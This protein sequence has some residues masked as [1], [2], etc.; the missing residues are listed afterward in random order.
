MLTGRM[1]AS[2][3]K[4]RTM[5]ASAGRIARTGTLLAAALLW[6]APA[7]AQVVHSAQFGFRVFFPRGLEARDANDVLLANLAPTGAIDGLDDSLEFD[8][9]KT[10]RRPCLRPFRA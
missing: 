2:A 9:C 3:S 8:F 5:T 10:D 4:E 1:S 7:F 6:T